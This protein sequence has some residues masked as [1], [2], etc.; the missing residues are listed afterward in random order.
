MAQT[1]HIPICP[2]KL[3]ELGKVLT[4]TE[5]SERCEMTREIERD[6]KRENYA[7]VCVEAKGGVFSI[8]HDG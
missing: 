6:T 8:R 7:Q 5:M 2:H 4:T 1:K 3:D